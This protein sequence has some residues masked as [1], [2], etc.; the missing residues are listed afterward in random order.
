[1]FQIPTVNLRPFILS[2]VRC[3]IEM[4]SL[5]RSA[6]TVCTPTR[7]KHS[8]PNYLSDSLWILVIY[9]YIGRESRLLL[10]KFTELKRLHLVQI[11]RIDISS[12]Q[13]E[14]F[15]RSNQLLEIL[16]KIHLITL[17]IWYDSKYRNI[18][19]HSANLT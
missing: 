5:T 8:R 12:E 3:V 14:H 2:H 10:R 19:L 7:L 17:S 6:F 11:N 1:M 15:L 13:R 9:P 18:F 16:G 4:C